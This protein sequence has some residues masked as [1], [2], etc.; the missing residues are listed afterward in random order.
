MAPVIT[1]I[2]T[3]AEG[4]RVGC[5]V[6]VE[7]TGLSPRFDEIVEL[8]MMLFAFDPQSGRI[9]GIVDQYVGLRDPGRTIPRRAT[10]VHGIR[11]ADVSGRRLDGRRVDSLLSRAEFMIAHN[12]SFDRGFLRVLYPQVTKLPWICSMR[13]VDWRGR[14]FPSR[15]LQ[16]LLRYHHIEV[17]RSHRGEDDVEAALRLLACEDSE[18]RC[19]FKE[20]LINYDDRLS[21]ASQASENEEVG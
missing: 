19:Y 12:A 5:F 2:H 1:R 6:D 7:T 4:C 10:A 8:A 13:G 9:E 14:G 20:V 16:S 18:G 21:S 3:V 17:R 15:G 11:D